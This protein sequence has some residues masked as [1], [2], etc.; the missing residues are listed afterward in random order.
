MRFSADCPFAA[1][2]KIVSELRET[3]P[4][5]IVDFH[6]EATSDKI[7]LA[8]FLDGKATAVLGTHTHVPTADET[9]FPGGTAFQCDVGMVGS[10]DSVLGREVAPI[11]QH[12]LSGMPIRFPVINSNVRLCGTVI[13][14][15]SAGRATAIERVVRDMDVIN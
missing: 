9:I 8:R 5:I 7:A 14:V 15:D 1:S 4:I 6:A 12:Y 3:T 2:E 13:T 10:K 11:I